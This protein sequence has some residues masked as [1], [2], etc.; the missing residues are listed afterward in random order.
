M[1]TQTHT[2]IPACR[3]YDVQTQ[4]CLSGTLSLL[5][6]FRLVN[7]KQCYNLIDHSSLMFFEE[8]IAYLATCLL[9][10]IN[11][12]SE[13]NL[14]NTTRVVHGLFYLFASILLHFIAPDWQ[15]IAGAVSKYC[16]IV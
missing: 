8:G 16:V 2:M 13:L 3:K 14:S 11:R 12:S 4:S 15:L 5:N 6:F 1:P 10:S 7:L 9:K